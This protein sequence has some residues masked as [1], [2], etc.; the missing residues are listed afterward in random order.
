M[1]VIPA[2]DL[3]GGRLARLVEGRP[4]SAKFY[5]RDPIEVAL[6]YQAAGARILHIVDLDGAFLGS[7]SENQKLIHR[8]ARAINIPIQV[9]GGIRSIRDIEML[10]GDLGASRV[11]IG[12]LAVERPDLLQEAIARF[13]DAIIS[14]IDARG[15]RVATRGWTKSVELDALQLAER[16]ARIGI[17][18][19]I[20][21]DITRDGKLRGPNLELAR[22]IA[23]SARV[24]VTLSGGI[25]S[26]ED[27]AGLRG[28][29][30]HG[31]D[32]VIVGRALYESRFKLEEAISYARKAD[33]TVPGR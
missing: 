29:E 18:R 20:Y 17:K 24:P 11:I 14:S 27:I 33:H 32:S 13:G 22:Q 26:L 7:L 6:E 19:I 4:E 31:V 1:E 21:T 23:Q 3:R 30:P 15:L 2:M 12:T 5:N 28:L 16:L 9:G 8:I 10:M 25:G